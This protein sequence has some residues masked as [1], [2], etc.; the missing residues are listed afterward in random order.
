MRRL[1]ERGHAVEYLAQWGLRRAISEW[2]HGGLR[3]WSG[4]PLQRLGYLHIPYIPGAGRREWARRLSLA[5]LRRAAVRR[6][7]AGGG[8]CTC[9]CGG[10]V[11]AP[12][13]S[14]DKSGGGSG[15]ARSGK[16]PRVLWVYHPNHRAL[17]TAIPHDLLVYD[18]MD[19]FAGF[20]SENEAVRERERLLASEADLVFTGGRSLFESKRGYNPRTYCFPSGVEY[21]HFARAA[22][23]ATAIPAD[24]E[25]IPRPRLGY[26]GAVDERIDWTLIGELCRRR[27]QWS[28]VFLGPLVLMDRCP[29]SEQN[30]HHL[31]AKPYS[32]LPNYLKGFDVCLMPFVQSELVAHISPTKTPEYLAGGRPVV[33]SP[34]PDVVA[35]YSREVAIAAT[36]EAF[37]SACETALAQGVSPPRKPPQSRTWDEIVDE[38]ESLLRDALRKKGKSG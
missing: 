22:D 24:L 13:G 11:T 4:R 14:G 20:R 7:T 3:R 26:F 31:G 9:G 2:R 35:D 15:G 23:P 21:S 16:T 19:H 1:A 28:I 10:A 18:C 36:P 27:P 6:Q 38:M 12:D 29:V 17:L 34:V 8:G 37:V 33:S 5:M 32:Q 25:A 30:F